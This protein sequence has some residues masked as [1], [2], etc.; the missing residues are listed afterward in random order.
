VDIEATAIEALSLSSILFAIAIGHLSAFEPPYE[1]NPWL[2]TKCRFNKPN[3][4]N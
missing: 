2:K 3:E 1:M 4:G